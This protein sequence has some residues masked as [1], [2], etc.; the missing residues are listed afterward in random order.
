MTDQLSEESKSRLLRVARESLEI[1]L[2]SGQRTVFTS[3]IPEL[4][5]KRA[6]F[7]TLRKK[8]PGIYAVVSD[9]SKRVTG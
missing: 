2:T 7:V 6:V 9:K 8:C 1:F 5:K 4:L 3:E